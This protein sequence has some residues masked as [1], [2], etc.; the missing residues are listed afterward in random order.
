M[1][2]ELVTIK[3]SQYFVIMS[4]LI[5]NQ[6]KYC[7]LNGHCIMDCFI[8]QYSSNIWVPKIFILAK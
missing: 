5:R 8:Y 7:A 3:G 6:C 4:K 2:K 1:K